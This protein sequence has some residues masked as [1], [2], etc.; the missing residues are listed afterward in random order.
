VPVSR[1]VCL[2]VLATVG[3]VPFL[4]FTQRTSAARTAAGA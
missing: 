3:M 4:R 1:A 2:R